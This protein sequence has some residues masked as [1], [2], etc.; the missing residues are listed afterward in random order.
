[1]ESHP[2]WEHDDSR[3]IMEEMDELTKEG[4]SKNMAAITVQL[5]H[6]EHSSESIRKKYNRYLPV[7]DVLMEI[8]NSQ[9]HR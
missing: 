5:K 4:M 7:A 1:M 8:R 6:Q 2:H 3:H 9:I